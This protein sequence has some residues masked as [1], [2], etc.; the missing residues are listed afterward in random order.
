MKT[1]NRATK[2]YNSTLRKCLKN[3]IP[4]ANVV[5]INKSYEKTD[6]YEQLTTDEP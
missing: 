6:G 1:I 3:Y 4:T 5:I 2:S